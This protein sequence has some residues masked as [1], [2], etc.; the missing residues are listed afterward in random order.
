M[1]HCKQPVIQFWL[2][3]ITKRYIPGSAHALTSIGPTDIG[4]L[5]SEGVK[6]TTMVAPSSPTGISAV[7]FSSVVAL[8]GVPWNKN[9]YFVIIL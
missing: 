2:M 8:I 5:G 3:Q 1:G 6:V 4:S 7:P 9:N